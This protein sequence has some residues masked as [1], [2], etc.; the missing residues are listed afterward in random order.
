MALIRPASVI[1][2]RLRGGRGYCIPETGRKKKKK[3]K[4]NSF[5]PIIWIEND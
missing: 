2:N 4:E 3:K 1:S 5:H